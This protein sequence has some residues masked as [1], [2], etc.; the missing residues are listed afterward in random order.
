MAEDVQIQC[1]RKPDRTNPHKHITHVGGVHAGQRWLLSEDQAI[2]GIDEGKWNFYVSAGGRTVGVIVERSAQGHRF[3]KTVADG[4][5]PDNL[6]SLP[7]C[8]P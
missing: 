7:E 6:L 1:I 5:R 3:L 8:P 4:Y 2:A